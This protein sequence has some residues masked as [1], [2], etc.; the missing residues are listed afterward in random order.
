MALARDHGRAAGRPS[1]TP[2][3][4][5]DNDQVRVPNVVIE[6]GAREPGH[7]HQAASLMIIDEPARIRYYAG[8]TL[9]FQSPARPGSVPARRALRWMNS[10]GPHPVQNIDQHRHHAIRVQ[11]K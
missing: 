9:Q 8:G 3:L 2:P 4:Q 11:L 1:L 10:D 6:P 7:T 5:L